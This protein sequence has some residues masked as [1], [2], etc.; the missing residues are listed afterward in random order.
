MRFKTVIVSFVFAGALLQGAAADQSSAVEHLIQKARSLEARDRA[1]LAAQV[2][3]QILINNPNQPDALAGLA[4]WAKRSGKVEE[5]NA[6]MAKLRKVSPDGGAWAQL[7]SPDTSK[8]QKARLDQAAKL[9]AAQHFDEAMRIYRDVFGPTPPA[10]G[11]ALAYYETLA[12]TP[13]GFEP[14]MAALKK[15][16]N[17]YPEVQDYQ[18]TAGRLLTY[19]PGTRLAGVSLLSTVE[20]S[21]PAAAKA[22]EAWRQAL[23]WEK[24]NRAFLP[25]LHIYLSRYSD[26]ELKAIFDNLSTAIASSGPEVAMNKDEQLG[27]EALKQ[28]DVAGAEQRFSA[29]LAANEHN[30]RA[31]AGLGFVR[32][33]QGDFAGAIDE[34]QKAKSESPRNPNVAEALDTAKF[35]NFMQSAT[36]LVGE[37]NWDGAITNYQSALAIKSSNVDAIRGMG[38]ALLG[39]G[40][41]AQALKYLERLTQLQ[42]NAPQSW[43]AL[44]VAKLQA[45][46][47]KSALRLARSLSP[48]VAAKLAV[49][50]EWKITLASAYLDA[51]QDEAASKIFSELRNA[52]QSGLPIEA[53]VQMADLQLRFHQP[54][55]AAETMQRVLA[56]HSENTGAWEI[57]ISALT[58]EGKGDEAESAYG[59]MPEKAREIALRHPGFLQSLAATESAKG[60]VEA[61][62]AHLQ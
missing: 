47:G 48:V 18:V 3:Q 5:A 42:P 22:K 49:Q 20:G 27:Y 50:P 51:G 13:D 32:M 11:W 1:D 45:E 61:G 31:R 15:L 23:L 59:R 14:A 34:F 54:A 17:E 53:Q 55:Q 44:V 26:S 58:A 21:T 2:W 35:W 62:I 8:T 40:R 4:R 33:K 19:R 57:L 16:A 7:D 6:Y 12:H 37:G 60:D 9:A 56:E 25:S 46:G 24:G 43:Q 36:K 30:S 29:A 28:A 38:G 52:D 39:A 10:G 41:P